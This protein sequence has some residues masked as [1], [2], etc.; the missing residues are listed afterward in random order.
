VATS[1]ADVHTARAPAGEARGDLSV[2]TDGCSTDTVATRSSRR[3]RLI[4]M[5]VLGLVKPS[6]FKETL[7][8]ELEHET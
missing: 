3:L 2:C 8:L 7:E 6:T 4:A 1:P 5:F